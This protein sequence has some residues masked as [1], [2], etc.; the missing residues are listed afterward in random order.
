MVAIPV[1]ATLAMALQDSLDFFCN[2]WT[3]GQGTL[4][5]AGMVMMALFVALHDWLCFLAL[6]LQEK[7]WL[8]AS[9][10]ALLIVTTFL[11]AHLAC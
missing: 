1:V 7:P 4:F 9:I 11:F 6:L 3:L 2:F 5:V 10:N 8:R